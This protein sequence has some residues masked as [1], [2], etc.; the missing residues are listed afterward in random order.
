LW[1]DNGVAGLPETLDFT[2][3]ILDLLL[4]PL[5]VGY[6]IV[7][8]PCPNGLPVSVRRMPNRNRWETP[9]KVRRT[10]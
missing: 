4:G 6:Q 5:A 9:T 3:E 2:L 1:S 8:S 10:A 7:A